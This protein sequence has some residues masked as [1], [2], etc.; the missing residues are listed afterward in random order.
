MKSL[1]EIPFSREIPSLIFFPKNGLQGKMCYTWDL[2][3]YISGRIV[4]Y[5]LT[6]LLDLEHENFGRC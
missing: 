2:F 1:V 5:F 6:Q 3:G 4:S